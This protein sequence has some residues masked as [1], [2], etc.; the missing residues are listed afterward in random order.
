MGPRLL[1]AYRGQPVLISQIGSA[2][3]IVAS[4]P[5]HKSCTEYRRLSTPMAAWVASGHPLREA[6]PSST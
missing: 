2:R 4:V 5:R 3:L 6:Q 1:A